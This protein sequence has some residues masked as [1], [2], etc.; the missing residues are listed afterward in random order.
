MQAACL[1]GAR[2]SALLAVG[3]DYAGSLVVFRSEN[4]GSFSDLITSTLFC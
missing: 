3:S 2:V 1:Q 4:V